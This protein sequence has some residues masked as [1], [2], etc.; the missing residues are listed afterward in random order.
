MQFNHYFVKHIK[1]KP[2]LN[3][4]YY[5]L[6]FKMCELKFRHVII[7]AFYAVNCKIA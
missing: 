2:K 6:L 4:Y 1:I 7:Q 5:K 3:C